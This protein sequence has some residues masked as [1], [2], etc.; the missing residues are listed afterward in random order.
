MGGARHRVFRDAEPRRE[1]AQ[2]VIA[3][4]VAQ[5]WGVVTGLLHQHQ[6]LPVGTLE[7]GRAADLAIVDPD[8]LVADP[9][10]SAQVTVHADPESLATRLLAEIEPAARAAAS[11]ARTRSTSWLRSTRCSSS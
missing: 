6:P 7:V 3:G 5:R 1:E 11:T 10:R 4:L 2:L 9:T 8:Q